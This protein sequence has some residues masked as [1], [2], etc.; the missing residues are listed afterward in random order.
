M[1]RRRRYRAVVVTAREAARRSWTLTSSLLPLQPLRLHRIWTNSSLYSET[2]MEAAHLSLP[3]RTTPKATR[4]R[5]ANQ[6]QHHFPSPAKEAP[7]T[8]LHRHPP[9]RNL[10]CPQISF[11]K[12]ATP[13]L[14]RR[15][16]RRT[17]K[18]K[19]RHKTRANQQKE[20]SSGRGDCCTGRE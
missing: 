15:P 4:P 14:Q 3:R 10:P 18:Q 1:R 5:V 6:L 12:W 8:F 2:V 11:S 7:R 20:V 13:S 16:E 9:P 19:T 17:R